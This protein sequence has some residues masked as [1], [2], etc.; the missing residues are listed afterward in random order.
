MKKQ[1]IILSRIIILLM[2]LFSKNLS[3]QVN[4]NYI[5][6]GDFE[7][8]NTCPDVL[9]T[10][11]NSTIWYAN[12][13]QNLNNT[14][15]HGGNT[16]TPDYF[17]S[18]DGNGACSNGVNANKYGIQS[19][20][21]AGTNAY[22]GMC[23]NSTYR[24]YITKQ[25]NTPLVE[26]VQ[27]E[28]TFYVS[29]SEYYTQVLNN[30][31]ALFTVNRISQTNSTKILATPQILAVS[32][33]FDVNNWTKITGTFVASGGEQWVTLGC[34]GDENG[35]LDPQ[36]Q[37]T[38]PSPCVVDDINGYTSNSYFFIDDVS[39]IEKPSPNFTHNN[40]IA[41]CNI[42]TV[43]AFSNVSAPWVSHNWVLSD[44]FGFSQTSTLQ[45][46]VFTNIPAGTYQLSHSI[47][48]YGVTT[49]ET[50]TIEV[51]GSYNRNEF[52]AT[53]GTATWTAAS[54]P[55]N[56]NNGGVAK[57]KNTLVIPANAR[58][59][60]NNMSIIMG[61]NGRI[62]V[63]RGGSLV[64]N[65]CLLTTNTECSN[66]MWQGIQVYGNPAFS[67]TGNSTDPNQGYLR[68]NACTI[69]HAV[70]AISSYKSGSDAVKKQFAGGVIQAYSTVFRNNR[71]HIIMNEY[72]APNK[73]YNKSVFQSNSF[74]S[75]ALLRNSISYPNEAVL[76]YV[77]LTM[78]D[79]VK[80]INNT[81]QTYNNLVA[82]NKRGTGIL[83]KSASVSVYNNN[84]F[85]DL[86]NGIMSVNTVSFR[87]NLI[88]NNYFGGCI[89]SIYIVNGIGDL[90][91]NN[92]INSSRNGYFNY[93]PVGI[94]MESSKSFIIQ[95]NTLNGSDVEDAAGL[96]ILGSGNSGAT[97]K[98]NT[99][100]EYDQQFHTEENNRLVLVKCNTFNN[101]N[102]SQK[103]AWYINNNSPS[104]TPAGTLFPAEIGFC[105]INGLSGN[106]FA[107][108]CNFD[109]REIKSGI[110]FKYN[111]EINYNPNDPNDNCASSIVNVLACT[112]PNASVS[113]SDDEISTSDLG[114][115]E[116]AYLTTTDEA[117]KVAILN[118]II[119]LYMSDSNEN[120]SNGLINWININ[121]SENEVLQ[122]YSVLH[123]IEES[124]YDNAIAQMNS[125]G[126]TSENLNFV[127][128]YRSIANH[129]TIGLSL[130]TLSEAI[131]N[132]AEYALESQ[133]DF[134]NIAEHL[135]VQYDNTQF[136]NY[137]FNPYKERLNGNRL[138]IQNKNDT[139]TRNK[140]DAIENIDFYPNPSS[141]ILFF[142]EIES[143]Y[144][145]ELVDIY[146][147][148]V[149]KD[150]INT[151]KT[152]IDL[153]ILSNGIYIV[154]LKKGNTVLKQNKLIISK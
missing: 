143:E 28:V 20:R 79:K 34:F 18:C 132:E 72:R 69:E 33:V 49:T 148:I 22:A 152:S 32:H 106:I 13:W 16:P 108:E 44:E 104:N 17:N 23:F 151:Q 35:T 122:K 10:S 96:A 43:S 114:S 154:V 67:Q 127:K 36:L 111:I 137:N 29:N 83:L 52:R 78:V 141:N 87:G 134:V 57:I 105:A 113:C 81:F 60:V 7:S 54:N 129:L 131:I 145:V 147:R 90:I 4:G 48:S 84:A 115:L 64:L 53:A 2:I 133:N 123:F 92:T 26:N 149:L 82:N 119:I 39:I 41:N 121:A 112:T 19:V 101:Y 40:G 99:F 107:D 97:I 136:V 38:L 89:R 47:I 50:K 153:N 71:N 66:T 8:S 126:N 45:N 46:P 63:E 120:K 24:E 138:T 42:N 142:E 14:S 31:G 125:L 68:L 150:F 27:Y 86:Y 56:N 80:F 9:P 65:N 30:L 135:L 37:T 103:Y 74:I 58:I 70:V 139:L 85:T 11:F 6:N 117:I 146:S 5:S 128:F 118:K 3:A 12:G 140:I 21:N 124:E 75:T 94:Y 116:S 93:R 59:T 77:E 55:L 130:D 51:S 95:N 15:P 144:E 91:T 25:L 98:G 109:A 73:A 1:K 76:N 110:E 100:S 61:P 62:I 102:L 88:E